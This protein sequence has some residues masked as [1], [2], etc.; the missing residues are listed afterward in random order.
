M[1]SKTYDL[2]QGSILK[3]LLRVAVPI[4]GTQLMQMTYNLT[5]MFWLGQTEQSVVAVASSG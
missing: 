2:T 4:M 5:D 1:A 3:K